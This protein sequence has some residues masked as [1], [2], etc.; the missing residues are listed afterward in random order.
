MVKKNAKTKITT[1]KLALM[2]AKGFENT[3]TKDDLEKLATK[4]EMRSGFR[5][6]TNSL[7]LIRAD[8]RDLKI[9]AEV[10]VK[11]LKHRVEQ[12][13]KKVSISV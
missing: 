10:D 5:V 11:D 4:E 7:D 6:V 3:A 9:S 8:I 12:L 13:E 1:E 2:V